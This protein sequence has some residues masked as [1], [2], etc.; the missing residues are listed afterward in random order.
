MVKKSTFNITASS[1]W[2][3]AT[4]CRIWARNVI[5]GNFIVQEE[6]KK[7]QCVPRWK[8]DMLWMWIAVLRAARMSA[9]L[10]RW[11]RTSSGSLSRLTFFSLQWKKNEGL[12]LI[13]PY[14][15]NPQCRLIMFK[16]LDEPFKVCEY[17][18]SVTCV[19]FSANI[20]KIVQL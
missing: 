8:C 5:A 14:H 6:E 9:R 16:R 11:F 18:V 17:G 20:Q 2:G 1:D 15:E 12:V 4:N 7:E 19:W 13:R 3:R 10:A